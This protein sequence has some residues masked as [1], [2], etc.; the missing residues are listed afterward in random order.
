MVWPFTRKIEEKA[1]PAGGALMIGGGPAWARKDK[2]QQY[3]TEG[4]QLNVIVY[5]AVNEI[6][7][8]AT[9]INVELYN[10]EDAVEL[11]PVLDLSL[12]HI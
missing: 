12:I 8:A 7:R 3:I 4:Y 2:S 1:H 5:R 11:H 10:G 6:V 9:S